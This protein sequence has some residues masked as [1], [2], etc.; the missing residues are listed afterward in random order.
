MASSFPTLH[1]GVAGLGWPGT[2]HTLATARTPGVRVVA[3]CDLSA[4]RRAEFQTRFPEVAR[5]HGAYDELLADPEV[6]AVIVCLPNFLHFPATR[7]ALAAGKHVLCEKPPTLNLAEMET[8]RDEARA[9]E[10]TYAFSRQFRFDP[11]MLAA[12]RAVAEGRLGRVYYARTHWVRQRGIPSVISD[13]FTDKT[14]AGGGALMDLGVHALDAAWFLAGC[15]RPSSVSAHV[16]THFADSVPA[17]VRFD[18]EDTGIAF[19]RFEGGLTILLEATWAMNLTDD[20]RPVNWTG[21]ESINTTLFGETATL[22]IEPPAIFRP[23]PTDGKTLQVL[24]LRFEDNGESLDVA[25]DSDAPPV[26]S[27][28]RQLTDFAH[29]VRAGEPPTNNADQAVELMRMLMAIYES[30][31]TGREVRF[32]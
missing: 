2:Q 30:G 8:V 27:F 19:L 14:R 9:Q 29:A 3:A 18:V 15:P 6:D 24:P 7:A 17:N 21:R 28:G 1:L 11:P 12:R 13:W 23:D 32:G 26:T 20:S 22:Q 25:T 31:E 16:G 5:L 10:L 4:Q